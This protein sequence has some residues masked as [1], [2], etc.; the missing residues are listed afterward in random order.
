MEGNPTANTT[1]TTIGILG[2]PNT[3]DSFKM[4]VLAESI[5]QPLFG[6]LLKFKHSEIDEKCEKEL[7]ILC[8]VARMEGKNVWHEQT[9]MR[10]LIKMKGPLRNLSKDADLKLCDLTYLGAYSEESA[11]HWIPETLGTPP[12]SGCPVCSVT[13]IDID[14]ASSAGAADRWY[15]GFIPGT[16]LRVPFSIKHFG[17]YNT[18]GAGEARMYGVFGQSGSGKSIIAAELIGGF[19]RHQQ[20]GILIID[21]QGEFIDDRFGEGTNFEFSFHDL[22]TSCGKTMNRRRISEIQLEDDPELFVQLIKSRGILKEL[23]FKDESKQDEL[24]DHVVNELR[25]RARNPNFALSQWT[26]QDLCNFAQQDAPNV[27]S[28]Q[29]IAAG[30][31]QR[32]VNQANNANL[33][34][35]FEFCHNLFRPQTSTGAQKAKLRNLITGFLGG[36]LVI[37]SLSD[38]PAGMAFEDKAII[39]NEI[40]G[41]VIDEA[42]RRYSAGMQR[43]NG[44]IVLDEAHRYAAQKTDNEDLPPIIQELRTQLETATKETRKYGLGWLFITQSIVSFSKAIYRQLTDIWY[45]FGLTIGADAGHV[46]DRVGEEAYS[47]Y[48]HFPNPKQTG[49][50]MF[51]AYGSSVSLGTMGRP[52]VVEGISSFNDFLRFNGLTRRGQQIIQTGTETIGVTTKRPEA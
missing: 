18:G 35:K 44:M 48:A 41:K 32:C 27:Y 15:M 42:S 19:A 5:S 46:K 31:A 33:R 49:K 47:M 24:A 30:V 7:N 43:M 26:Y 51:L 2:S 6:K 20:M 28:T 16:K 39:V 38:G 21:P 17:P 25:N 9:G 13:Q 40:V 10:S 34:S 37:I 4:D 11:T 1:D 52:V 3:L 12:S 14:C 50:Y 22:I 45:G 8:Q 23:G 36:E 29:S